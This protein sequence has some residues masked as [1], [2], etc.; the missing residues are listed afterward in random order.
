MKNINLKELINIFKDSKACFFF[1]LDEN[2]NENKLYN[3]ITEIIEA[4]K[5]GLLK[6]VLFG[7]SS[8]FEIGLEK[9][10]I[11]SIIQKGFQY[12]FQYVFYKDNKICFCEKM[13]TTVN[14]FALSNIQKERF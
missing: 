5:K 7:P 3:N 12:K 1:V 11:L 6:K 14:L 13:K 2:I 10:V 4:K 8:F 9:F